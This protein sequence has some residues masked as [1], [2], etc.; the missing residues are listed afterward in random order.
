[1]CLSTANKNRKKSNKWKQQYLIHTYNKISKSNKV[2]FSMS[3]WDAHS[4]KKSGLT[5]THT[6][7]ART[8]QIIHA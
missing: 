2:S 7:H 1:M 5:I 6:T 8:T 4:T 3:P